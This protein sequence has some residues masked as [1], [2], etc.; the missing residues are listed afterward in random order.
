MQHSHLIACGECDLLQR[1]VVLPMGSTACCRRCGARLYRHQP[2]SVQRG[3]A[4]ALASLVLFILANLFPIVVLAI[5]GERYDTTLYGAVQ[6]LWHQNMEAVAVLVSVTT[7]LMPALDLGI[8]I[9]VLLALYLGRMP[10][11]FS[12]LLRAVQSVRPWSMVEVFMLGLLVSPVKL[13]HFATVIPGIALWALGGC[14]LLLIAAAGAF[15][16]R[17]LWEQE[18]AR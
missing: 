7:M 12:S 11:G 8:M 14:V 5:Q 1:K 6:A 3:L 10:L 9:Y 4:Y 18:V 15:N 13:M 16:P 2:D 17:D